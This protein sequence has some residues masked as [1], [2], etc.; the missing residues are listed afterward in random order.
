MAATLLDPAIVFFFPAA[1]A[2]AASMDVVTMTIP[3]RVSAALVVGYLALALALG[4]PLQSILIHLSCGA[5]VLAIAFGLYSLGWIGGGDAK[6][7]AATGLWF[8]WGLML[9]Y[10]LSAAVYGGALTLLILLGRRLVLPVF[11][12]RHVWI[13]R[14]HDAKT[15]IPYGV[16]LAAAGL[17]LYPHTEIWRAA[18]SL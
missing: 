10:S 8:G 15:G 11:L 6:L 12:T 1:M 4:L 7:A 2:L 18:A 13:A 3:N 9:D 16:A 14:L 5:G 17:M